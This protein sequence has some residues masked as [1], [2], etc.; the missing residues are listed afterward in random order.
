MSAVLA[1]GTSLTVT[2]PAG[3]TL[4]ASGQG[5]VQVLPPAPQE[6]LGN[7]PIP[8]STGA[9]IGPLPISVRVLLQ[10]GSAA[11]LYDLDP[12][13]EPS[14]SVLRTSTALAMVIPS[15]GT[16]AANGAVT[17]TTAV[18]LS[19]G[20]SWGCY[21]YFPAGA[22]YA[23]SVAGFYFTV[24]SSNNL[25]TVYDN[26]YAGEMPQ[27]PLVP[28]PIVAAGPGA[29][30][31][32][33]SPVDM[34]T[35]TIPGGSMGNNGRLIVA[36]VWAIPNNANNK[37]LST[38]FGGSNVY[39]KT[40]TTATQEAP[41]VDIRNRGV[42]TRQFSGWANAGLPNVSSTAGLLNLA[43]DT[44]ADVACTARG[45]L[46]VATDFIILESHSVDLNFFG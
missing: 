36:P 25:G 38:T 37:T 28:T 17:L 45:Q 26:R 20:Y 4:S 7:G 41:L 15:S 10:A 5:T 43:V 33:L 19:G 35:Y 2:L 8:V 22:V 39:A 32:T 34:L 13:T 3:F 12:N 1:S 11:L 18:P 21:M 30:A 40:R 46:A 31:Q 9:Q 29:Y 14:Y 23:G 27:V 16:M 24:M 44:T 6:A 42:P